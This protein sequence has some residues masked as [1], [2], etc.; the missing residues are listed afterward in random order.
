MS[1]ATKKVSE[2]LSK[3]RHLWSRP[4]DLL[5]QQLILLL[6]RHF[7]VAQSLLSDKNSSVNSFFWKC[8]LHYSTEDFN[9]FLA[10]SAHSG[11]KFRP[12]VS[13]GLGK[14]LK[15]SYT[16]AILNPSKSLTS[17]RENVSDINFDSKTK[18]Y[19]NWSATASNNTNQYQPLRVLVQCNKATIPYGFE[20]LQATDYV[21]PQTE[22]ALFSII[23][24]MNNTFSSYLCSDSKSSETGKDLAI[25][26]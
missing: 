24:A 1:L 4:T 11:D 10:S 15:K 18:P 9:I 8:Q 14:N 7:A 13:A 17:C 3:K 6:A 21:N 12:S 5:L 23:Q 20:F 16:S 2:V 25:V 19:F 22:S 26:S